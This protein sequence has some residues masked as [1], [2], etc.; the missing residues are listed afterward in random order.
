[1]NSS[2]LRH[3]Y[4]VDSKSN[5]TKKLSRYSR[6]ELYDL[7]ERNSQMLSNQ[8]VI[9]TLPD[10]G[11]KLKETNQVIDSLLL[12]VFDE[13]T[14]DNTNDMECPLTEKLQGMSV[15]TPHQGARK[16]SVDLANQQA[17]SHYVSSGLLLRK[18]KKKSNV[19]TPNS[20][21]PSIFL[22]QHAYRTS[23]ARQDN[24]TSHI[25]HH[26]SMDWTE[27]CTE[28]SSWQQAKV[29]MLTLDESLSLQSEQRSSV[30]DCE[31]A[32][33]FA[34]PSKSLLKSLN[35]SVDLIQQEINIDDVEL[36]THNE[37][38][39]EDEEKDVVEPMLID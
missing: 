14:P 22:S 23:D 36:P 12:K 21:C 33:D 2:I 5:T 20:T 7:R 31:K 32:L 19:H 3:P 1:M 24:Q 37:E 28:Y 4:A 13:I 18:P 39:E 10:K 29:R 16:R 15:L 8:S 34:H 30:K 11:A 27:P 17:S 26:A 25:S 38:S 6:A 35:L 9:D